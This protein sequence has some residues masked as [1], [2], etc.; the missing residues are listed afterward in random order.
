MVLTGEK[1]RECARKYRENNKELIKEKKKE[2][3]QTPEGV[4]S[5]TI[6]NWKRRGLI[7]E[8]YDSLYCHYLNATECDN[9]GVEF[10][11]FRDGSSSYKTMDHSHETG[12]FR[13]F[14]CNKCNLLRR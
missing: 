7:C 3:R 14:L 6:T 2:W 10:G 5:G 1:K 11:E 9:C 13:N 12:V 4:K 8:D